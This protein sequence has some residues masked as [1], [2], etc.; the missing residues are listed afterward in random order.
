M[1]NNAHFIIVFPFLAFLI[2]IFFGRRL[3]DLSA[4]VSIVA[5]ALSLVLSLL[6]FQGFQRGAGSYTLG[7]WID[8]HG[9]SLKF[10]ITIDALSVMMLLTVTV[11]AT[12]IKIYSIEAAVSSHNL[13][14]TADVLT[15]NF[16][17]NTDCIF[18]QLLFVQHRSL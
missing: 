9:T 18:R 4:F 8:F 13:I 15:K 17:F 10:G 11:I 7:E 16:L 1:V 12:L 6:V 2:N 3:K 5:S 14:L